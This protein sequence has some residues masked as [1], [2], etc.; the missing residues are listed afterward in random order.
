MAGLPESQAGHRPRQPCQPAC[1]VHL[2]FLLLLPHGNVHWVTCGFQPY[3]DAPSLEKLSSSSLCCK[4]CTSPSA[5]LHL[6]WPETFLIS[7]Y[8]WEGWVSVCSHKR[9]GGGTATG[10]TYLTSPEI[11]T[12]HS[13]VMLSGNLP[14]VR[15]VLWLK[16]ICIKVK[17]RAVKLSLGWILTSGWEALHA[18][19]CQQN[20]VKTK[21]AVLV[22][23]YGCYITKSR[24]SL[25]H[26]DCCR[27]LY[28][29]WIHTL[30]L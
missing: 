28:L 2:K 23:K 10:L 17:H 13:V 19:S 26:G 7:P 6:L 12:V 14:V 11:C 5:S 27:F 15:E 29:T 1:N 22:K 9:R 25:R 4:G 21:T 24:A 30:C 18:S 16:V 3:R 8:L 20:D